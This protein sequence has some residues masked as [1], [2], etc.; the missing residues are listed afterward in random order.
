MLTDGHRVGKLPN[1]RATLVTPL[2]PSVRRD[3]ARGRTTMQERALK[4]E[5]MEYVGAT[6][7]SVRY[8]GR[9][10]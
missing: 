6:M 10:R 9:P 5:R 7:C 4:G 2:S 3:E 8:S 1:R